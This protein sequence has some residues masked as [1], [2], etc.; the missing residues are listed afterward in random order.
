MQTRQTRPRTR[1]RTRT[2]AAAAL[3]AL[4]L[5]VG[6]CGS[7][8]GDG[9]RLREQQGPGTTASRPSTTPS[10]SSTTAAPSTSA[11][12]GT[13]PAGTAL[14]DAVVRAA[15]AERESRAQYQ[16]VIDALGPI[17]PFTNILQAEEQH[18]ATIETLAAARDVSLPA[19]SSTP[20]AAPTGRA[21]ACQQA[22]ANEQEVIALYE[23]LLPAAAGDAEATRVFT[24]L[25]DVS[26]DNHLP[27]FTKCS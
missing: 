21:Q 2:L 14:A 7:D 8:G 17:A 26:R 27:A 11:T 18:V 5:L 19:D 12:P 24:N 22:V 20:P 3:A 10:P 4:A 1:T 16:A 13:V 9:A 6:A 23:E 15:A 25:R